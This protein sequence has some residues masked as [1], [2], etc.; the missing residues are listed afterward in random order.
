M[1]RTKTAAVALAFLIVVSAVAEQPNLTGTWKWKLSNQSAD[2]TLSLK[3]D[4]DKLT[5]FVIRRTEQVPIEEATYKD[6]TVNFK[7]TV[8]SEFGDGRKIGTKF[9][10]KLSG[11][12]IKGTVEFKHPDRTISREWNARRV[13]DEKK[14]D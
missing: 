7:A 6:G 13:T 2:N 1:K 14:S 3:L 8:T 9:S 10:G 4:G 11:D 5:G 12:K